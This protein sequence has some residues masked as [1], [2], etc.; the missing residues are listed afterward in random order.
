M[1]GL[2]FSAAARDRNGREVVSRRLEKMEIPLVHSR[3][4]LCNGRR[5]REWQR[6]HSGVERDRGN[7]M[8]T[9]NLTEMIEGTERRGKQVHVSGLDGRRCESGGGSESRG[10]GKLSECDG[11]QVELSE[12]GY[13]RRGEVFERRSVAKSP[14]QSNFLTLTTRRA[15]IQWQRIPIGDLR[16]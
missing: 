2:K 3:D 5:R 8:W 9:R 12:I 15:N 1:Q 14:D 7:T 6:R 11:H 4:D 13:R 10:Y 16:V